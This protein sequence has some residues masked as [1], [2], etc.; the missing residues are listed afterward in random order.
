MEQQHVLLVLASMFTYK[1]KE[2]TLR[3]G[4]TVEYL[5]HTN[6]TMQELNSI[7]DMTREDSKNFREDVLKVKIDRNNRLLEVKERAKE[8][9]AK[10][11]I[12]TQSKNSKSKVD[13]TTLHTTSAMYQDYLDR[14]GYV[15]PKKFKLKS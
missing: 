2:H 8:L 12:A 3:K 10:Q 5:V 6:F 9:K 7:A 4:I 11:M 13:K 1:V 14:V 15:P